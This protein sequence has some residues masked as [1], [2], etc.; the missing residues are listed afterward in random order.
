MKLPRPKALPRMGDALKDLSE[1]LQQHKNKYARPVKFDPPKLPDVAPAQSAVRPSRQRRRELKLEYQTN[2]AMSQPQPV[3]DFANQQ[4]RIRWAR[5]ASRSQSPFPQ[6]PGAIQRMQQLRRS[7]P[8]AYRGY[9]HSRIRNTLNY[10]PDIRTQVPR[11]RGDITPP[12][13][14][15][16][17]RQE[18]FLRRHMSE[19]NARLPRV[20]ARDE[21]NVPYSRQGRRATRREKQLLRSTIQSLSPQ[22]FDDLRRLNRARSAFARRIPLQDAG[23]MSEVYRTVGH[24]T[25]HI[26]PEYAASKL[27][28]TQ[29]TRKGFNRGIGS[30]FRDSRVIPVTRPGELQASFLEDQIDLRLR[31]RRNPNAQVSP[32]LADLYTR[33]APPRRQYLS[34]VADQIA[35]DPAYNA[36]ERIQRL[37]ARRQG[38]R[39]DG[40]L[41]RERRT[42][43]FRFGLRYLSDY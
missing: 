20:D 13:T 32:E 18:G 5:Q 36:F 25:T 43:T 11:Q 2:R 4:E 8:A 10:Q 15:L 27:P 37:A 40:S 17:P 41:A 3:P 38:M 33:I 9:M 14:E 39:L 26:L 21:F 12:N 23:S 29:P 19:I 7:D 35:N 6:A 24:D 30:S 28:Q 1:R 16:K 22:E 34:E 42:A 31:R